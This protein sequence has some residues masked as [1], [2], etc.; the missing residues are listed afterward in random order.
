M[1]FSAWGQ[2]G[3]EGTTLH[4]LSPALDQT[5]E[6]ELHNSHPEPHLHHASTTWA[7][8]LKSPNQATFSLPH[9]LQKTSSQVLCWLS[10]KEIASS[11]R[12]Y[13]TC[14][15]PDHSLIPRRDLPLSLGMRNFS[16]CCQGS[17]WLS[18][19]WACMLP[20]HRPQRVAVLLCWSLPA[21]QPSYSP[22]WPVDSPPLATEP[23]G[24]PSVISA[25]CSG[26]HHWLC[27]LFFLC[28]HRG[29]V[30]SSLSVSAVLHPS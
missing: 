14:L 21:L 26:H 20:K 18:Q 7:R 30:L 15:T 5:L 9:M 10:L 28:S 11:F 1:S 4:A 17:L 19:L 23:R 6:T 22:F 13:G 8:G 12:L 24:Q 16:F 29:A 25:T 3:R 27:Y 2:L